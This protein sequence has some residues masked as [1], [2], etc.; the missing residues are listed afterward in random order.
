VEYKVQPLAMGGDYTPAGF[1]VVTWDGASWQLS[2][3]TVVDRPVLEL[4]APRDC[5]PPGPSELLV[6]VEVGQLVR[7]RAR[8]DGGEPFWLEPAGGWIHRGRARLGLGLHRVELEAVAGGHGVARRT[9]WACAAGS[10]PTG[11]TQPLGGHALL[12]APVVAGDAVV[13]GVA[14]LDDGRAGGVVAFELASGA[15]RWQARVGTSVTTTPVVHAGGVSVLAGDG[16]LWTVGLADGV[17]RWR[18][19]LGAGLDASH[20]RTASSPAV[21][22]D[23]VVA[24]LQDRLVA[25]DAATGAE[26]WRL[27]AGGQSFTSHHAAVVS[28][29]ETI[30]AALG[31]APVALVGVGLGGEKKWQRDLAH[32]RLLEASPAIADGRVYLLL[33]DGELVVLDLG[34]G[35]TLWQKGIYRR[36]EHVDWTIGPLAAPVVDGE[37]V[38]L[39]TPRS[40]RAIERASQRSRWR[41]PAPGSRLRQ[42]PLTA[43]RVGWLNAPVVSG[44]VVWIGAGDGKLRGFD[45]RSGKLGSQLD[46][47]TPVTGAVAVGG[48]MLFVAGYDGTLRAVRSDAPGRVEAGGCGV[49]GGGG[50]ASWLVLTLGMALLKL[51]RPAW[52]RSARHW[53]GSPGWRS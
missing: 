47:G 16:V 52:H 45:R 28:D 11:W 15:P 33:I 32:P 43:E 20:A 31:R 4:A 30:V 10:A 34:T 25:L 17:E 50:N 51:T 26:R 46:L 23:L 3:H 5:R 41:V 38:Y 40:L 35:E 49:A 36:V 14:D 53:H 8:V 7:V 48:D 37:N 6:S 13:V 1:R 24:A 12:G 9:A 21:A 19:D 44:D 29:G 27:S 22:G 2:H 39:A 42:L 18:V